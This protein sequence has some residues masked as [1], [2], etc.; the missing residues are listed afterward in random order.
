MQVHVEHHRELA[1][2]RPVGRFYGGH[3]TIELEHK[4]G[5]LLEDGLRCIVV[6]LGR[7]LHLNSTAITTLLSAH[8]RARERGAELRL[9]SA[10]QSIRSM[11]VILKLVNVLPVHDSP[12]Q[13]LA[14]CKQAVAQGQ[15]R[16]AA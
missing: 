1:I 4:L 9:C 8:Q 7:T 6:D 11:L 13:A 2:V 5:S 3:E 12:E 16:T 15:K 14:A 10:D